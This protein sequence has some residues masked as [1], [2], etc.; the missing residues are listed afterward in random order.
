VRIAQNTRRGELA[1]L[2]GNI[3]DWLARL[4]HGAAL[5]QLRPPTP[6]LRKDE[7]VAQAVQRVRDDIVTAKQDYRVVA[8]APL[9][10]AELKRLARSQVERWGQTAR[11]RLAR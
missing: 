1:S 7:T 4:P 6:R 5:A 8:T 10:K 9:P 3:S 11:P 2:C